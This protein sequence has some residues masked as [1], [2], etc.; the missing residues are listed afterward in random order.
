MPISSECQ[1]HACAARVRQLCAQER[2][3]GLP[4]ARLSPANKVSCAQPH[5]ELV[6]LQAAAASCT[7]QAAWES[8]SPRS[9]PAIVALAAPPPTASC[10]RI[11]RLARRRHCLHLHRC[12]CSSPHWWRSSLCPR[13][14]TAGAALGPRLRLVA[15]ARFQVA[16]APHLLCLPSLGRPLR[17]RRSAQADPRLQMCWLT[18]GCAVSCVPCWFWGLHVTMLPAAGL[19]CPVP[20]VRHCRAPA[21]ALACRAWQPHCGTATIAYLR[22]LSRCHSRQV[23]SCS[24]PTSSYTIAYAAPAPA[25]KRSA[26]VAQC[27]K[28]TST[29]KFKCCVVALSM[30]NVVCLSL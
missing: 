2:L 24:G 18:Q 19:L 21:A 23:S 12:C 3:D 11:P 10:R 13:S 8:A 30:Q 9:R 15:P 7:W 26:R 17:H 6:T 4:A 16:D 25:P 5:Q 27:W 22:Q 29:V 1:P 20:H 14:R 28:A